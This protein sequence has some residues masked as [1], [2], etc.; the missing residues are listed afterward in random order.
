MPPDVIFK[1]KTHPIQFWFRL[2]PR[3]KWGSSQRSPRTP[4][5]ILG[6]STSKGEEKKRWRQGKRQGK[7]GKEKKGEDKL[8][9]K[10]EG[11]KD[12]P[13]VEIS[14]Y[15]TDSDTQITN[16][17]WVNLLDDYFQ[18]KIISVFKKCA[19]RLKPCNG[20]KLKVGT[21][22]KIFLSKILILLLTFYKIKTFGHWPQ[23]IYLWRKF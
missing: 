1:A 11:K 4:S 5:W 8:G 18:H 10:G 6:G 13:P 3:S 14:G 22:E 9:K 2:R 19:N 15:G 23:I 17:Q 16:D 21:E 7:R 20:R 12:E